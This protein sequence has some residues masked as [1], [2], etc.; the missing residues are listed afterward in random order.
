MRRRK[1]SAISPKTASIGS[2]RRRVESHTILLQTLKQF[3]R[4]GLV[5]CADN[6]KSISEQVALLATVDD[7]F[8]K[9]ILEQVA[10]L[11]TVDDRFFKSMRKIVKR[12]IENDSPFAV[13]IFHLRRLFAPQTDL[14]WLLET[15]SIIAAKLREGAVGSFSLM[16]LDMIATVREYLP[17]IKWAASN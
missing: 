11:A 7:R 6:F 2:S 4:R 14:H 17:D 8:F 1:R 12:L 3:I 9:S 16:L 10:L 15:N 5:K 13:R